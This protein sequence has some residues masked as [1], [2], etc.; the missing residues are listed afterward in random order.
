M[1]KVKRNRK[2]KRTVKLNPKEPSLEKQKK[3]ERRVIEEYFFM[4]GSVKLDEIFGKTT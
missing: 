1:E 4:D 2:S 3:Q